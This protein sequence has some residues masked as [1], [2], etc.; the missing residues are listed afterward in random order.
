MDSRLSER[1]VVIKLSDLDNVQR[2]CLKQVMFEW[3]IPSRDSVVVEH[4]WDIYPKV[5]EMVLNEA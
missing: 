4:D 1:Y 2:D 5:V 3:D